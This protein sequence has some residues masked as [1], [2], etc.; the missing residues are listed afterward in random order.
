MSTASFLCIN[1][2]QPKAEA[3]IVFPYC[4]ECENVVNA[5]RQEADSKQW[6]KALYDLAKQNALNSRA[7]ALGMQGKLDPRAITDR[8]STEALQR[9]IAG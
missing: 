5:V 3:R 8:I 7:P 9:R 1:C 6:G 4:D 2:R